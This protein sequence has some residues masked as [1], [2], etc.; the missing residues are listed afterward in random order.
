MDGAF[1]SFA[2]C[3]RLAPEVSRQL[4]KF[5]LGADDGGRRQPSSSERTNR[6]YA[7]T[8]DAGDVDKWDDWEGND[9]NIEKRDE[10]PTEWLA[11]CIL[12]TFAD[13]EYLLIAYYSRFA[14]LEKNPIDNNYRIVCK[15]FIDSDSITSAALFGLSNARHSDS[16]DCVIAALGTADGHVY[17]YTQNGALIF[18]ERFSLHEPV[19]SLQ[20]ECCRESQVLLV[21]FARTFFVINAISLNSTL[22]QAKSKIAKGEQNVHELAETLELQ[23]DHLMP[24]VDSDLLHVVYTGQYQPSTFEQYV[25]ASWRSF[26]ARVERPSLPNYST[27]LVTTERTFVAFVWHDRQPADQIWNEAL[28]YGKSLLPSFGLRKYLGGIIAAGPAT[29]TLAHLSAATSA[30]IRSRILDQRVARAVAR[31]PDSRYVAITDATARVVLVDVLQRTIVLIHK[32]YRDAVVS[33]SSVTEGNRGTQFL[34]I[35]APRRAL[36]EIWTIIGN[37]RVF[38]KHVNDGC[39]ILAG[40][41]SRTLCGRYSFQQTSSTMFVDEQ[42]NF[43]TIVVPFYLALNTRANQDQHDQMLL[44]TIE[45]YSAHSAEWRDAFANF[46]V[47]STRCRAFKLALKA[48]A[49]PDE[50]RRFLESICDLPA[51]RCLGKALENLDDSIR[52]YEK[53]VARRPRDFE[54]PPPTT[55]STYCDVDQLVERILACHLQFFNRTTSTAS[56]IHRN[57]MSF[58][59]FLELRDVFATERDCNILENVRNDAETARIGAFVLS[60]LLV[61]EE[62]PI[63]CQDFDELIISKLGIDDESCTRMLVLTVPQYCLNFTIFDRLVKFLI[64]LK[65]RKNANVTEILDDMA[66][67]LSDIS[68]AI[69]VLTISWLVKLHTTSADEEESLEKAAASEWETVRPD[70]EHHDSLMLCLHTACLANQLIDNHGRTV[71]DIIGHIESFC[72]ESVARWLIREEFDL[73]RIDKTFPLDPT[74]VLG[75]DDDMEEIKK[76][77]TIDVP[78]NCGEALDRMLQILP[79]T[80]EHDLVVADVCWELM[81][82]WFKD[83]NANH[84]LIEKCVEFLRQ[85]IFDAQLRHGLSRLIWDKFLA[86][87]F[88]CLVK[89]VDKSGRSPTDRDSL[90]DVGFGEKFVVEFL[91]QCERLLTIMMESVRDLVV[92]GR[93]YAHDHL[94]EA[95][96]KSRNDQ[97]VQIACKQTPANYHLVLH[98][99][100]LALA[101][102]LQLAAGVRLHTLQSL[103]CAAGVRA[104]F[105]RL[106]SHPLIPLDQVDESVLEKRFKFLTKIAE[107]GSEAERKAAKKLELEWNLTVNSIALMQAISSYRIGNDASGAKE[108]LSCVRDERAATSLAHLLA[109]RILRLAVEE[110]TRMTPKHTNYLQAMAG[111][112]TSRVELADDDGGGGANPTNWRDSVMSLGRAAMP[113]AV[114]PQSATPF[115]KLNDICR[116]YWAIQWVD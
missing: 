2:D 25:A 58:G 62:T 14:V 36:I 46:K 61:V 55:T 38:A 79:R 72:R 73:A 66:V 51:S 75:D 12:R 20:F 19:A 99:Y 39:L 35:Y 15:T 27:F 65:N 45:N 114:S 74:V 86:T 49:T 50:A 18:Y 63:D 84:H 81:T 32:G 98:H 85:S 100:Q 69:I 107:H 26:H 16:L 5:L 90:N 33:W 41:E 37:S 104:F 83:K 59:E 10:N 82:M 105:V 52:L 93:T 78:E 44:K 31:S 57:S 60:R 13:G 40:G 54:S 76:R 4:N 8:E 92:G 56:S 111:E 47:P 67:H 7:D 43:Q 88:E 28:K 97:L 89:L 101:L 110:N 94:V 116:Q 77:M 106:D 108:L 68:L 109:A 21:V 64:I 103:F 48:L 70:L 1:V 22:H 102:R 115:I 3:C 112:E 6:F 96:A 11:Q 95:M 24:D 9:A 53:I 29:K 34:V 91:V 17:F 23:F 71:I 80:F 42:G 30:P 113:F 87:P